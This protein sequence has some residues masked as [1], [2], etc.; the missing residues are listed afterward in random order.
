MPMTMYGANLTLDLL[1]GRTQSAPATLYVAV[2][3]EEAGYL[4]EGSEL[5]EPDGGGYA[6]VAMPNDGIHWHETADGLASNGADVV[7]PTATEAWG[8]LRFWAIC[9]AATDGN[10]ITWGGM[11]ARLILAGGNLRFPV[12]TLSIQA[13]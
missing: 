1:F 13:R 2:M 7:F 8:Q 3:Y 4:V 12:D 10:V 5:D 6:R 9:D 11:S